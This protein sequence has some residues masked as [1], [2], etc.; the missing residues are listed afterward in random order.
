MGNLF[1]GEAY[2]NI[3]HTLVGVYEC[4][5]LLL[6]PVTTPQ[7]TRS[8]ATIEKRQVTLM[9]RG[10]ARLRT[11][12][13]PPR[14]GLERNWSAKF[15][16][17]EAISLPPSLLLPSVSLSRLL[18]QRPIDFGGGLCIEQQQKIKYRIE[19]NGGK[20]TILL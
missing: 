13:P 4:V 17:L 11:P 18:I 6:F 7:S 5:G 12:P 3:Q 9:A 8:A 15:P 14:E 16:T 20:E 10:K 1:D 19:G 2:K